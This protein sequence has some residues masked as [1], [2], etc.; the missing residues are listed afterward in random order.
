MAVRR[1]CTWATFCPTTIAVEHD[2]N[3]FWKVSCGEIGFNPSLIQPVKQIAHKPNLGHR[4][5]P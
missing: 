3:V 2:G 5:K 1:F 4:V